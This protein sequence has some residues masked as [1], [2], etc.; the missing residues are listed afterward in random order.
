MSKKQ[1]PAKASN[2]LLLSDIFK[3]VKQTIAV[4]L[5]DEGAQNL[6]K[7]AYIRDDGYI[8]CS[9]II[10]D[11]DANYLHVVARYYKNETKLPQ[12][13]FMAIPNRFVRYMVA[14]HSFH[15]DRK[16]AIG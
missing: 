10:D 13:A 15:E 2:P 6:R 4:Y 9:R 16:D 14:D 12:H 11:R 8:A 7:T 1:K 3:E 5:T